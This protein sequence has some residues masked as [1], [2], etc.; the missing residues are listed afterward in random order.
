MKRIFFVLQGLILIPLCTAYAQFKVAAGGGYINQ[1]YQKNLFA[2]CKDGWQIQ[3][4]VVYELTKNIELIG[5]VNFQERKFDSETFSFIVPAVLIYPIPV[6]KGGDN[7][8]SIGLNVGSRI[9]SYKSKYLSGF[10]SA[11]IG[12]NYFQE[13]FYELRSLA[14]LGIRTVVVPLQKYSDEK[15]L[16][17]SS[18]GLGVIIAPINIFDIVLE[19]RA[20]FIPVGQ[21]VYFP[22]SVQIRFDI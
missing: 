7:L 14:E 10:F 18:I 4:S 19:G 20:A 2:H 22:I 16:F 12:F 15:L 17:E 1:P 21:L 13:S 9:K 11:E 5:T 6:I 8:R 3:A